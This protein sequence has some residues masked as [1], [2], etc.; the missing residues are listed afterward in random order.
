MNK[1]LVKLYVPT[2]GEKYDIWI[3]ANR[4]VYSVIKLITKAIFELTDGEYDP[5]KLPL[6]YDKRTANLYDIN[7]TIEK[8]EITNGSEIILI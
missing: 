1:V 4:S 3:P 6:L 2:I 7:E 5:K 8:S